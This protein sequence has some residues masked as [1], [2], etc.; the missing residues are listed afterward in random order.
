MS[1]LLSRPLAV[2]MSLVK[3]VHAVCS[4]GEF[5]LLK[6]QPVKMV[7][8]EDA[9]PY[10]V[11]T[12]HRVPIPLMK[13]VKEE[14]DRT[15]ANGIIVSRRSGVRSWWQ[16]Q[17]KQASLAFRVDRKRLNKAVKRVMEWLEFA[18]QKLNAEKCALR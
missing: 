13:P 10:A 4:T 5:G 12:A 2:E 9:Q 8:R 18:G 14:L 17:T 7:L 1:N 15:E 6:T 3:R 16:P 11:H